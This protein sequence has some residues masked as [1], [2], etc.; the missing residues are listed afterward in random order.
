MIREA[1]AEDIPKLCVLGKRFHETAELGG[2]FCDGVFWQFCEYLIREDTG[3]IFMSDKGMIGGLKC[4]AFWDS[5]YHIARE[6]FWWSEDG[7]GRALKA[8][9]EEWA[10]DADEVR[11][12]F[13]YGKNMRPHVVARM[14]PG[15]VAAETEMVKA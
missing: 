3:V 1:A 10:D 14:F 2:V 6:C 4:P 13:L 9:Y 8:A 15:Y 7:Q 11:M 12:G 5:T